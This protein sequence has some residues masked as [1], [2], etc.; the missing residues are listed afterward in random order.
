MASADL[1]LANRAYADHNQP[2][3]HG[4]AAT[5]AGGLVAAVGSAIQPW[6]GATGTLWIGA[7]RGERDR[8]FVDANGMESLETHQG[9]ILHRRLFFDDAAWAG[10]YES[11]SNSFLWPALHL[12]RPGLTGQA[13]FF[14]APAVP[15]DDD[16]R[17][18]TEVNRAFAEAAAGSGRRSAWVHDYQLGLV[19]ALLRQ[20]GFP[21]PIGFF[22]H[23]PFPPAEHVAGETSPRGMELFSAFVRGVLGADLAAFQT[24]RDAANFA[25]AAVACC[26]A[27]GTGPR[28]E[29]EGRPVHVLA[30]PVGVNADDV[31]DA[32]PAPLPEGMREAQR[33]G[34]K[35][36][37]ALE[38]ADFTKGIPARLAAIE[39]AYDQGARFAYFGSAS[40]TREGIAL[41]EGLDAVID[42]AAAR[43]EAAARRAGCPFVQNSGALSWDEVVAVLGAADVVFTSSLADGMNLVPLQAAIAQQSR[44]QRGI[45][46]AGKDAGV[47]IAYQDFAG[48]GLVVVDPLDIEEMARQLADA[49]GGRTAPMSDRFVQNVNERDARH[50]ASAFMQALEEA[51]ADH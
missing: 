31:R 16:W 3:G 17:H 21:G 27:S 10:H 4:E 50:W 34:L 20:Q 19:P 38:R 15:S 24:E 33:E 44:R 6:D 18:Y 1:I 28:L 39:R 30:L 13:M 43:A 47:S 7:G 12:V 36:V 11:V 2:P 35:V 40:P 23:T 49:T 46:I 29:F 41:Y 9:P 42:E 25:S 14:P 8:E 32:S 26:G 51:H 37:A 48:E 45:A 22:L 5:G